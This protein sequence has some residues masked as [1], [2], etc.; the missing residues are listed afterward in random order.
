MS[1]VN[2]QRVTVIIPQHGRADLTLACVESFVE[3][4]A[5][6][7]RV[8]VVDDGSPA[9]QWQQLRSGLLRLDFAGHRVELLRQSRRTGVTAAWNLGA[10]AVVS[11]FVVFLNN[12]TVTAGDWL[13]PLLAPLLAGAVLLTGCGLRTERLLA[14]SWQQRLSGK[15]LP[16]WVLGLRTATLQSLGGFDARMAL[17]FSDTDLQL[18]LVERAGNLDVS[19]ILRSVA[20]LPL[21]HLG[22]RSTRGLRERSAQWQRDRNVFVRKWH[23][24]S[25]E[26]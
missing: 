4:H 24:A 1:L 23:R 10:R 5:E 22:H 15:L 16:G 12:D 13:T 3:H 14:G 6:A 9:D 21:R 11:E 7:S 19:D 26:S 25:H 20:E 17:Y 18:R 2:R 8:L